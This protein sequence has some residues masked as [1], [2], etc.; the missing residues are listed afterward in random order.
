MIRNQPRTECEFD[1]DHIYSECRT[2]EWHY[3]RKWEQRSG[4]THA[5]LMHRNGYMSYDEAL[6]YHRI[7]DLVKVAVAGLVGVPLVAWAIYWAYQMFGQWYLGLF[8]K[9]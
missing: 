2:P 3:L 6:W 7:V 1:P 4:E 5:Q 9:W 8:P